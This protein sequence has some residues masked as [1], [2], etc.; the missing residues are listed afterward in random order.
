[1][2]PEFARESPL[3][4]ERRL[5]AAFVSEKP[6]ISV[7]TRRYDVGLHEEH[8]GTRTCPDSWQICPK[9]RSHLRSQCR[10]TSMLR[11]AT[12]KLGLEGVVMAA[13]SYTC[14]GLCVRVPPAGGWVVATVHRFRMARSSHFADTAESH[15]LRNCS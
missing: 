3:T 5:L 1:M 7:A 10:F 12:R 14:P 6:D 13:P 11:T 15:H 2:I 9:V 4:C 8:G